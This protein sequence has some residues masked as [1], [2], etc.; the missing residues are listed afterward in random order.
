MGF[1]KYVDWQNY[2]E[3]GWENVGRRI[4]EENCN[5]KTEGREETNMRYGGYCEECEQAEDSCQPMMNYA[6]PLETTPDDDKILK[7]C[8]ETCLTVMYNED[9]DAYFLALC[10]G[11]MD[12]SQ[13]I[14]LAYNILE[15]WIPLELALQVSTQDGLNL[16]GKDF[17]HV[18]RACKESIKIDMI[19]GMNRLKKIREAIKE[20]LITSKSK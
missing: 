18:M 16:S 5:N 13:Q 1:T 19:N 14:A 9:E 11:G 4:I 17:R 3:K 8:Q 7:V 12:L 15:R 20:S 6:Y 2:Y 10:G